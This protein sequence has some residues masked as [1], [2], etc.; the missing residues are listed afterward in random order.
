[1]QSRA[2]HSRE[3]QRGRETV[4]RGRRERR[5]RVS[6]RV[7]LTERERERKRIEEVGGKGR[8]GGRAK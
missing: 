6:R 8:Q 4:G 1:L 3:R 2:E 5:I 7:D